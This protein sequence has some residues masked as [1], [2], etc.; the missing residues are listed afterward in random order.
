MIRSHKCASLSVAAA[1]LMTAQLWPQASSPAI[2]DIAFCDFKA[3]G[4]L[5]RGNASFNHGVRHGVG[6][7]AG[8]DTILVVTPDVPAAAAVRERFMQYLRPM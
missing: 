3:P 4:F 6:T 5:A 1:L 7:I 2:T 8:G